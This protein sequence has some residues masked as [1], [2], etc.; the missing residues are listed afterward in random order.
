MTFKV[1]DYRKTGPARYG[2]MTLP[3][4]AFMRRFLLHVLPD[5]FHRIRHI[6]FLANTKRA[7]EIARARELLADRMTP[8]PPP[9]E[10]PL[11]LPAAEAAPQPTP[12]PCCGGR[13]ILFE[14]IE[15]AA[16]LRPR[17]AS[18]PAVGIDSS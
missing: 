1:K 2:S 5:G 11:E 17:R 15:R 9:A 10:A 14:I 12:C 18:P 8:A 6:G 7:K 4:A 13:M 3:A 16:Y